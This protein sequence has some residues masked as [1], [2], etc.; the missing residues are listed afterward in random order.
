MM[1]SRTEIMF[2]LA[3][4][5]LASQLL[6]RD[7]FCFFLPVSFALSLFLLL[8]VLIV[9]S[10]IWDFCFSESHSFDSGENRLCLCLKFSNLPPVSRSFFFGERKSLQRSCDESNS[11][12]K[13]EEKCYR[14]LK[15]MGKEEKL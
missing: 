1:T 13:K 12:H 9:N 6:S 3:T 11:I 7:D 2:D 10:V 15:S 4:P 8:L 14:E 5:A